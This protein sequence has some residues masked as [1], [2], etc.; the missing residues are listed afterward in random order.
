VAKIHL[1]KYLQSNFG[2][3][4]YGYSRKYPLLVQKKIAKKAKKPTMNPVLN[5]ASLIV[6]A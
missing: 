5:F 6:D 3:R 2:G 4:G 1:L